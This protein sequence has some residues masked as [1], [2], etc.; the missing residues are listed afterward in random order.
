[1]HFNLLKF[2]LPHA[3]IVLILVKKT[4]GLWFLLFIKKQHCFSFLYTKC[5]KSFNSYLLVHASGKRI[6]LF[7]NQ[8]LKEALVEMINSGSS[9]IWNKISRRRVGRESERYLFF[10]FRHQRKSSVVDIGMFVKNRDEKWWCNIEAVQGL[11]KLFRSVLTSRYKE[12]LPLLLLWNDE[13]P[14]FVFVCI[15]IQVRKHSLFFLADSTP[16]SKLC[17]FSYQLFFIK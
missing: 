17:I 13:C 11:Q 14:R 4:S 10:S 9:I 12:N 16:L 2:S 6:V 1:M 7:S 5:W 8:P 15:L 3:P